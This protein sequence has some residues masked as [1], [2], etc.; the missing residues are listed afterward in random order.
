MV[1]VLMTNSVLYETFD[2]H[3][4]FFITRINRFF[5]QNVLFILSAT[6]TRVY[7]QES[8]HSCKGNCT[9]CYQLLAV[10]GTMQQIL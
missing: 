2:D 10:K 8:V 9:L 3:C 7:F 4:S 1:I 5:P 6:N